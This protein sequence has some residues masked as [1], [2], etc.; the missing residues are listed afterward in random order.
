MIRLLLNYVIPLV[1]PTAAYLI[2]V[3][4]YRKRAEALGGKAPEVTR[5]AL[6]WCLVSGLGL[7]IASLL[8]LAGMTGVDPGTGGYQSP[9]LEDG[10][11]IPPKF[12]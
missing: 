1:M 2:W 7:M 9:R 11:I 3:W 5:G 6:F 10:R 12:N 8:V 4:Y